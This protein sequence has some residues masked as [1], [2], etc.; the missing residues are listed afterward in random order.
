MSSVLINMR[1]TDLFVRDHQF[2]IGGTKTTSVSEAD[3]PIP[4]M[5]GLFLGGREDI[6]LVCAQL[7]CKGGREG[8]KEGIDKDSLRQ[9]RG[10]RRRACRQIPSIAKGENNQ[11]GDNRDRHRKGGC[12]QKHSR[13]EIDLQ[14]KIN[15]KS[16]EEMTLRLY[17][18]LY[19][20]DVDQ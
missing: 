9:R 13:R 4:S 11:A 14:G 12:P 17:C 3:G 6:F 20:C 8:G 18:Q 7:P 2:C 16:E 10:I 5:K 15:H 1:Q 19:P